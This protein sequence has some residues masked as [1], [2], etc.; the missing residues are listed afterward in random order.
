MPLTFTVTPLITGASPA[1]AVIL[2]QLQ[3]SGTGFSPT[4]SDNVVTLN[5]QTVPVLPSSSASTLVV[6]VPLGSSGTGLDVVVT[7]RGIASNTLRVPL[8]QAPGILTVSG[9]FTNRETLVITIAGFDATGDV[10]SASMVIQ[11]G[12]GQVLGNFPS[13]SLSSPAA[14]QASFNLAVPFTNANHFTAAMT[15]AVQLRDGAGNTSNVVTGRITNPD[16]RPKPGVQP[17]E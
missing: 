8:S 16:I 7:T 17:L 11:D 15:V 3:I 10:S 9:L 5:G 13:V 6:L 12:E 14:N 2:Q 4:L 1:T